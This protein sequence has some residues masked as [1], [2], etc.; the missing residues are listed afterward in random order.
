MN[1]RKV[2]AL[3]NA[4]SF[5]S[6]A[7]WKS[8]VQLTAAIVSCSQTCLQQILLPSQSGAVSQIHC[9]PDSWL[10]LPGKPR[11]PENCFRVGQMHSFSC[12]HL[13]LFPHRNSTAPEESIQGIPINFFPQMMHPTYTAAKSKSAGILSWKTNST[14]GSTHYWTVGHFGFHSQSAPT[15]WTPCCSDIP[16]YHKVPPHEWLQLAAPHLASC[17]GFWPVSLAL[18]LHFQKSGLY[19][20]RSNN[21]SPAVNTKATTI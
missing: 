20:N 9:F 17:E 6:W 8:T 16:K 11:S 19:E 1:R 21:N 13:H 5:G 15:S 2:A 14:V 10:E 12:Q 7:P 18:P 4:S 3:W